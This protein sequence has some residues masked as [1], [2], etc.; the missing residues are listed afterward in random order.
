MKHNGI[1]NGIIMGYVYIYMVLLR[2]VWEH[3]GIVVGIHWEY[4]KI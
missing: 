1:I 2:G 3:N 4:T